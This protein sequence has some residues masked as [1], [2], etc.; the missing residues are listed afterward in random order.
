VQS[1]LKKLDKIERVEPPRRLVEK[2]F[3]FQRAPR[4]GEDVIVLRKVRKG[5]GEQVVHDGVDL[6]VRRGERWAV[7]GENG[8]GKTTLLKIMAGA[9]P[10]DAGEAALGAGVALGYYAQHQMELLD[11]E[12][13]V[14]G[15]LEAHA[16]TT[17]IGVL[18]NLAGAFGFHGDD[19]DK[20]VRVLSGGERA[21]L[22]LAKI[23]FDAPN[24]LVLDEPTN[25]LD[26]VTKR[27]VV[28]ALAGYQGTIVFVSHD[29]AFLRALATR[30]LE[31]GRVGP[32]LYGGNYDEYVAATG[33]EAPGMREAA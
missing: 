29:R 16:P 24:L 3:E 10:P 8:A 6:I 32:R 7:M 30:V 14:F 5:Y 12:R 31:L 23:L 33:R 13:T 20:P 1:R 4:S 19:V 17:G 28:R 21:R 27:A 26:L 9:L 2:H 25:H 11:G 22:V 18:R 15:E